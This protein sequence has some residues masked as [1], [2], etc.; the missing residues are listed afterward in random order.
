MPEVL[1]TEKTG[2]FDQI[3][4]KMMGKAITRPHG[5]GLNKQHLSQVTVWLCLIK[6]TTNL[7]NK[8]SGHT[9]TATTLKFGGLEDTAGNKDL[10]EPIYDI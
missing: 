5:L 6:A 10:H 7:L 4:A 8:Q 9:L 3:K 2:L 1:A